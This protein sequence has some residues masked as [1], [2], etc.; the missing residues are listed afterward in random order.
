[1]T[2][3]WKWIFFFFIF[4]EFLECRRTAIFGANFWTTFP[5]R[6]KWIGIGGGTES[7]AENEGKTFWGHTQSIEKSNENK[8]FKL[9]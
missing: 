6:T 8:H 4:L 5:N 1:M 9:I 7:H 3:D 2:D